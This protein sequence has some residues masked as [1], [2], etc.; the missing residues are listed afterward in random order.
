MSDWID[1]SERL[2]EKREEGSIYSIDVLVYTNGFLH[3]YLVSYYN[4][5]RKEWFNIISGSYRSDIKFWMPI[6]EN[7]K[8]KT[9]FCKKLKWRCMAIQNPEPKF[10]LYDV[11]GNIIIV[12]YCPFCGEKA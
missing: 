11:A 3:P 9:H 5:E 7:A 1:A 4:F 2:P 6:P 10:E 8:T 12:D